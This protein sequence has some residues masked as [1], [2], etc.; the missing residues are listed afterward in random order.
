M[1][2]KTTLACVLLL[3]AAGSS[4]SQEASQKPSAAV[5]RSAESAAPT[6][7]SFSVH[8]GKV[9]EI[10]SAAARRQSESPAETDAVSDATSKAA[11]LTVKFKAPRRVDHL[12][13]D[14][15]DCV[16]YN[17]DDIA[18]FTIPREQY[19]GVH[20]NKPADAWLACQ[21]GDDLLTTF[22]RYDK[23][24]GITIGLPP[25]ALGN[26]TLDPPKLRF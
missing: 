17:A 13:C 15:I 3:M 20:G 21:S 5:A 12:D 22:E 11:P 8:D 23:C 16:A 1:N 9:Q 4:W 25:A 10:V 26:V 2:V 18:L 24:R 14:S 6:A 7:P 19:Y